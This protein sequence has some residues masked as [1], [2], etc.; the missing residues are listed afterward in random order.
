MVKWLRSLIEPLANVG[1][2]GSATGFERRLRMRQR[3]RLSGGASMKEWQ[4]ETRFEAG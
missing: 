1:G 2:A 3:E 4:T